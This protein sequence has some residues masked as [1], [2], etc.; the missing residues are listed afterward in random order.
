MIVANGFS[1]SLFLPYSQF[2]QV[3]VLD[4]NQ[5]SDYQGLQVIMKR[6]ISNGLGLQGSYTWSISKDNGSFDPTFTVIGSST[7]QSGSSAAFDINNRDLNYAWSDFDRRHVFNLQYVWELPFGKSRKFASDAP[8]ALDWLIGGWQLAGLANYSSGRPFTI[9]SGL[10]TFSNT[11]TSTANCGGCARN[12][13]HVIERNGTSY[14]FTQEQQDLISSTAIQPK[15]GELGDTGRNYFIGPPDFRADMSLSK[16]F[17]FTEKTNLEVRIDG[18]NVFNSVSYGFPT[19]TANS[20]TFTRIR[21]T[22]D[23]SPR[24]IQFSGKFNF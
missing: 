14:F 6:R 13:G 2:G 11:V 5:Y 15:P 9:F 8:L 4:T 18:K 12:L 24:R 23:S 3:R 16:K 19:T 10:F 1:S 17:R 20:S 7:G 22:I 21:T